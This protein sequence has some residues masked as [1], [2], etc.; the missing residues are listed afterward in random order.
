MRPLF[1]AVL[2]LASLAGCTD[3]ADD[4]G[5]KGQIDG[6]ALNHLLVPYSGV[7]VSLPDLGVQAKTS[8]L[9]GFSFFDVPVGLYVVELD[10][11]G[12]GVD[13]EVVA[14]NEGEISRVI[15]Q[16]FPTAANEPHVTLRSDAEI[17]QFAMPGEACEDCAWRTAVSEG[18]PAAVELLVEWDPK[19]PFVASW[20]TDLLVE[21]R[22][23]NDVLI[24]GPLS[25][26]DVIDFNG[27]SV[28]HALV[29]GPAMSPDITSLKVGFAFD[30]G[31]PAPHP[32]FQVDSRLCL[33]YVQTES[34]TACSV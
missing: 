18:R 11:P 14:V 25:K 33:H 3:D 6:A 23:Q 15:L 21:L 9:G 28:L 29:P 5:P 22:D 12:V 17:V 7:L 13:R 32:D 4:T 24:A 26:A 20:R 34:R 1:V 31:N 19:H 27:R 16:L 10:I 8:D 2:L 30:A